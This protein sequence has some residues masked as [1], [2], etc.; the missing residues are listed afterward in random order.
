MRLTTYTDYTLRVLMY[1]ASHPGRTA[2]VAEIAA[3]YGISAAHL[4]KVVQGAAEAGE[5]ETLRG[6]N[7]GIRLGRLPEAINL[8]DV[9]RRT[10]PDMQLAPCFADGGTCVLTRCCLLQAALGRAARAFMAELG[11]TTLADLIGPGGPN[12]AVFEQV[13]AD[14]A[15]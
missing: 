13:R 2:T 8:A 3:V 1:L 11:R 6:R 12:S 4:N 15:E 14:A 5:V 10:E 9:V 7:G